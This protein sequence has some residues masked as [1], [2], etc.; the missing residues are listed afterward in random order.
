MDRSVCIRCG[1]TMVSMGR[2]LLRKGNPGWHLR[3]DFEHES[4]ESSLPV[5][6]WRCTSCQHLDFYLAERTTPGP[7]SGIAQAPCP[8]CG[9]L[10]E[11]DDPKCPHCGKRL[12]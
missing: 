2:Q 11:L 8:Y 3:G 6:V 7:G 10:H 5:E 9:Q 1:G 12:F 4:A